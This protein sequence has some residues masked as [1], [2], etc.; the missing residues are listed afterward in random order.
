[1]N[2]LSFPRSLLQGLSE[3]NRQRQIDH[4]I[5]TFIR[6]LQWAAGQGDTQYVYH[7]SSL[8]QKTG[9]PYMTNNELLVAF[10]QMFPDCAVY[11]KEGGPRSDVSK[12]G[13]VI[14]WA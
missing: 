6:E 12:R 8:H 14:N 3:Q 10:Q 7:P 13:I 2:Y 1:M 5:H 11:Y 9:L 4:V